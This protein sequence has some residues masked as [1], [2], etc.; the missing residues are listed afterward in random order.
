MNIWLMLAIITAVMV[1]VI[2]LVAGIV[3]SIMPLVLVCIALEI[4]FGLSLT[5]YLRGDR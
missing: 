1:V 5:Y 4:L 3:C 2:Q